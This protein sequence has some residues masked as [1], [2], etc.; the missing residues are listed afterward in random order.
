[1]DSSGTQID[2][3]KKRALGEQYYIFSVFLLIGKAASN[4]HLIYLSSFSIAGCFL[5]IREYVFPKN[6]FSLETSN[7]GGLLRLK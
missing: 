2:I 7:N 5:I 6:F 1:M 3:S 4:W